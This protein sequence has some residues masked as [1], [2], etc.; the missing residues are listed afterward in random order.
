MR[1]KKHRIREIIV[2]EGRYDKNTVSQVVDT[3][4][5]ETSGYQ[6]FS[7]RETMNLLRRLAKVRGIIILTDSDSAGFMIRNYIKGS[8]PANL[9]KHAY[10]PDVYG[11]E[12]RK[13]SPSKEGKLG[14]EGMS[15]EIILDSLRRAGATFI[16]DDSN[17][18]DSD[19]GNDSVS[20]DHCMDCDI[21]EHKTEGKRV[22]AEDRVELKDF[23]RTGLAGRA[24]SS[25]NRKVLLKSLELPERMSTKAL[26]EVVNILF[27]KSG[28]EEYIEELLK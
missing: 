21:T 18:E 9:I 15:P 26:I 25:A 2:V 19:S 4:I 6:I 27:T 14:V 28:F 11:K 20:T 10:I 12:R 1:K 24:G 23:F 8:V 7:N 22:D 13:S 16:G 17:L 3:L 5:V